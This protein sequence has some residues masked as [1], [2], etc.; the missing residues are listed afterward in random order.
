MVEPGTASQLPWPGTPTL[1]VLSGGM[2]HGHALMPTTVLQSV[3]GAVRSHGAC[4]PDPWAIWESWLWDTW[5][6]DPWLQDHTFPSFQTSS[7]G[8]WW[9]V[10]AGK[11]TVSMFCVH[12]YGPRG[13]TKVRFPRPPQTPPWSPPLNMQK[14]ARA[15]HC[16]LP[17][18]LWCCHELQAEITSLFPPV[19][20]HGKCWGDMEQAGVNGW[21]RDREEREFTGKKVSWMLPIERCHNHWYS[22]DTMLQM[23]TAYHR[24]Q[25]NL[26]SFSAAKL[27]IHKIVFLPCYQVST[28]SFCTAWAPLTRFHSCSCSGRIRYPNIKGPYVH[29]SFPSPDR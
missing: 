16:S 10:G 25:E 22:E 26:H 3:H 20:P 27:F 28:D 5:L 15:A 13:N 18:Q 14:G 4:W 1:V 2:R 19:P 6:W 24:I 11:S 8:V 29:I 7:W 12:G 23:S 9:S 21:E 17:P